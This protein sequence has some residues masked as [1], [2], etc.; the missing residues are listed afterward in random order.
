MGRIIGVVAWIIGIVVF[1]T[2]Y[3]NSILQHFEVA[4]N[5]T[6]RGTAML[7]FAGVWALAVNLVLYLL[8]TSVQAKLK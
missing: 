7:V 4:Q 5:D 2:A 1:Y 6:S 3:L 8:P